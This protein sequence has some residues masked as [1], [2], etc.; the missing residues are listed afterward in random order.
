MSE[1]K[2]K[3]LIKSSG[4]ETEDVLSAIDGIPLP[5]AIK[6]NLWKSLGRLITGVVD[7]PVAYL[8]SKAESIKG[9]TIALN[10]FRTKVAEKASDE[11]MQDE[12]L[13]NRA[14][15]YYGS[16][17]LKEQINREN[18]LNKATD[19]LKLNPPEKDTEKE[20]DEDWLDMFSRISE[21]KSN[22]EVQLILSKILA[23]E[24]KRPGSFGPKTLQ[25][26][27]LLDHDTAKI[28]RDFCSISYELPQLGDQ[29]V[30]VICQPFGSPGSNGLKDFNLSYANLSQLQDAGLIQ[31]DL[32]AWRDMHPA[33]FIMPFKI[34]NKMFQFKNLGELEHKPIRTKIINF[35]RVGLELR[36]VL[37]MNSNDSYNE[38]LIEWIKSTFKLI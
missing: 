26:L 2:D 3:E 13:M 11:F 12:N 29:M 9:E 30:Q 10:V 8:E 22:E 24:I 19:E 28:F 38:K 16:K 6:K 23:G 31:Y 25:T 18:V 33:L 27:T 20:I 32:T 34:G 36:R 37:E 5:P 1:E 7:I 4:I 14:V 17:L 21:T 35:T 15:D